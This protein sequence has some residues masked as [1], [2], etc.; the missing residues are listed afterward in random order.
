MFLHVDESVFDG[1]SSRFPVQPAILQR[2]DRGAG[3]EEN[4][5]GSGKKEEEKKK[6]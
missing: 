6:K 4:N 2:G 5:P 1:G 3:E